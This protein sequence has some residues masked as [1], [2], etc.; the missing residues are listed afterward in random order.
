MPAA[1]RREEAPTSPGTPLEIG[2]SEGAPN[3]L[4][5]ASRHRWWLWWPCEACGGTRLP[6]RDRANFDRSSRAHGLQLAGIGDQPCPGCE[7]RRRRLELAGA[8]PAVWYDTPLGDWVV[9][10]PCGA[11]CDGALLPLE[12]RWYDASWAE[13]Y[14]AASD[15]IYAHDAL[16]DGREDKGPGSQARR[17]G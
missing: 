6:L 9:R 4:Y 8:E 10:V 16:E 12:I 2:R 15:V 3:I 13:V 14:R 1:L 11:S 7:T 17:R 5:Q